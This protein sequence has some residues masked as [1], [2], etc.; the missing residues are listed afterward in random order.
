MKPYYSDD[1]VDL[2]HA[3]CR[4]VIPEL[5]GTYQTAIMDPVWPE[6]SVELVGSEDPYGLLHEAIM[7]LGGDRL[8]VQL[9]CMT[10]PRFLTAIPEEWPFF[11][12][13]MLEYAR[14]SYVGRILQGGDIAYLFG[15]PPRSRE[16]L[17]LIPGRMMATN[18]RDRAG[19]FLPGTSPNTPYRRAAQRHPRH[20]HRTTT[21]H[22]RKA[23]P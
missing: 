22:Y 15:K 11:R 7:L 18:D 5:A 21:P 16:G 12:S 6:A 3:D 2:Y 20:R 23:A 4:E 1:W 13:V 14:P 17:R 10:D 8:A 19:A 9:S